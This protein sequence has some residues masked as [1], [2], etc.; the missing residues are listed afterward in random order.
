MIEVGFGVLALLAAQAATA[1]RLDLVCLG[2]GSANQPDV[3]NGSAVD[4]NGNMAWGQSVGQRAVPFDDQ[5]NLWVVQSEGEIMLPRVM[6]PIIRG[7]KNGW[8]KLKDLVITDREI[9]GSAA[10]NPFNNPKV[11]VDRITGTISIAGKAGN[12]SGRCQRY[13]PATEKRAF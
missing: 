9:T 4:S 7:G 3:R 11:R 8:F 5:V 6:L 13:D 12:Y 10:V 1:S 2:A